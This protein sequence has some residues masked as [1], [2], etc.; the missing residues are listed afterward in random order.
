M[1][2][3]AKVGLIRLDGRRQGQDHF[4]SLEEVHFGINKQSVWGVSG[5]LCFGALNAWTEDQCQLNLMGWVAPANQP[6]MA[7]FI[8]RPMV[9]GPWR[10]LG[11]LQSSPRCCLPWPRL[12]IKG[13]NIQLLC[14][15]FFPYLLS[16]IVR[17]TVVLN[18][19][20]PL[21]ARRETELKKVIF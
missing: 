3:W 11:P 18:H 12:R 7:L 20:N 13:Y 1:K 4:H 10:P 2:L 8:K 9:E 14:Q 19:Y 16:G 21:D 15:C 17:S 6:P 5:E